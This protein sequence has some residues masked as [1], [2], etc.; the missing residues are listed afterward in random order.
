MKSFREL[1]VSHSSCGLSC[2]ISDIRVTSSI[3][4]RFRELN[5]KEKE[6]KA[7]QNK[8]KQTDNILS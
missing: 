3:N 4:S 6:C 7:K 8:T 1:A 2:D 5:T